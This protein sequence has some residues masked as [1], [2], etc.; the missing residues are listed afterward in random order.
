MNFKG[1]TCAFVALT[2]M[3]GCFGGGE[4]VRAGE[5]TGALNVINQSGSTFTVV[6]IS[7]CSA[8]SHGFTRLDSGETIRSGGSRS[9]T[10]SQ[11]CYDV[12]AGFPSSG[13]YTASDDRIR[14]RAGQQYNLTIR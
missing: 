11:G 1:I 5:P 10:V 12:Q 7:E 4:L 8:A 6:T 3:S 2:A 13:G 9:W 14:I